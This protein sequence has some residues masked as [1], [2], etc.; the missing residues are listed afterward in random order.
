MIQFVSPSVTSARWNGVLL[1]VLLVI[2]AGPWLTWVA[3]VG[4]LTVYADERVP[5]GQGL[6]LASKLAAL[7]AFVAMSLQVCYGILGREWRIRLGVEFGERFH[8]LAGLAVVAMILA[9]AGLF[10]GGVA[11]RTHH[12]PWHFVLPSFTEGYYLTSVSLGIVGFVLLI[13]AV[14]A[15]LLRR[16]LPVRGWRWVHRFGLVATVLGFIHSLSIGSE[17]RIV[18]MMLV[19]WGLGAL[20][21]SS[22]VLRLAALRAGTAQ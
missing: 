11:I 12:M 5:A 13:A 9:H 4:D 17:S 7:Y 19:Y 16:H 1:L 21:V 2:A 15:A 8:R 14:T 20:I 3:S 10:I 6:Y 18:P 22:L